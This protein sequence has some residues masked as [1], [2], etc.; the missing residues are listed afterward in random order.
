MHKTE[1]EIILEKKMLLVTC[2]I[3]FMVSVITTVSLILT[4][5]NS[6]LYI[7]SL[8]MSLIIIVVYLFSKKNIFRFASKLILTISTLISANLLWIWCNGISVYF[9]ILIIF[10]STFTIV[11]WKKSSA[12]LILL[13]LTLNCFTLFFISY[14][15]NQN[16]FDTSKNNLS[17]LFAITGLVF[18]IFILYYYITSTKDS[19]LHQFSK[20]KESDQLKSLF[21][22]NISHE[23]RTPL[24]AITGFSEL[25]SLP[26]V[27]EN[28]KNQYSVIIK[29]NAKILTNL[30]N[31]ILDITNIESNQLIIIYSRFNAIT[32]IS[33]IVKEANSS[34]DIFGKN[35]LKINFD[36][37]NFD[38]FI[39]SDEVRIE[40]IVNNLLENAIK[41]TQS[42]T[43]NI[44][45]S[46]NIKRF[47]FSIKDT[48]IGIPK[49]HLDNIFKRFFKVIDG[50][51][52]YFSGDGV[53]LY[54]V[55][56]ILKLLN[57]D[58][59][60]E[61]ETGIGSTFTFSVPDLSED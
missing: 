22:K 45:V 61:S 42:G 26:D 35:N 52:V 23:I 27:T 5:N 57:G 60:V 31:N 50:S 15:Y 53:G 8:I 25:I 28:E 29:Q 41:F 44:T 13:F 11:V 46:K 34:L 59:K 58:I 6:R 12:L 2:F 49:E 18:I 32:L 56:E 47:V 54:L 16:S 39:K 4:K 20:A 40:Q 38:L 1:G 30:I 55:K 21:L 10:L 51:P 7:T 43:I 19:Y 9:F 36:F 37:Q 17:V 3:F 24:N 48:G 14:L 33:R